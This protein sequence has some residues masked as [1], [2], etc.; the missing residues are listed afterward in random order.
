MICE[1]NKARIE[2][3]DKW[4]GGNNE[5]ARYIEEGAANEREACENEKRMQK[6]EFLAWLKVFR[7][8]ILGNEELDCESSFIEK[9]I[10][11]LEHGN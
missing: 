5:K 10:K 2:Q 6:E 1:K 11:E 8:E 7:D 3:L 4:A 9:K